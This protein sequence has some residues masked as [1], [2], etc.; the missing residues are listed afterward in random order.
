MIKIPDNPANK[1]VGQ[2]MRQFERYRGFALYTD[3][4]P[5]EPIKTCWEYFIGFPTLYGM[6]IVLASVGFS[7]RA[8]ARKKVFKL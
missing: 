7:S 5:H 4:D 1:Y 3:T 2:Q 8:Q 6:N